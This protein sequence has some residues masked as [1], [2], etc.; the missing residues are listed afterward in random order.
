M[1]GRLTFMWQSRWIVAK[2]PTTRK[3]GAIAD[4]AL[5]RMRTKTKTSSSRRGTVAATSRS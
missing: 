3:N 2:P 1:A 4:I 5:E